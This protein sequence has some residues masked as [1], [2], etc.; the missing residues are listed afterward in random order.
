MDEK[1]RLAIELG[2]IIY[3]N[4]LN[5]LHE[6]IA[7]LE[8]QNKDIVLKF[9]EYSI[10]PIENNMIWLENQSGEGMGMSAKNFELLLDGFFREH[11]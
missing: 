5:T 2:Q 8:K 9:G 10:K 6:K 4:S 11:Y 3:N 7:K 1:T